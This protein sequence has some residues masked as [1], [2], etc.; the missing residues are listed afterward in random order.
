MDGENGVEKRPLLR[1]E[2][3]S[4]GVLALAEYAPRKCVAGGTWRDACNRLSQYCWLKLDGV[5]RI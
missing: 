1:N 3:K 2:P 5:A 4:V